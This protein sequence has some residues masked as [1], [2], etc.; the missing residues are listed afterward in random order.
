VIVAIGVAAAAPN[1]KFAL[2]N[3]CGNAL[4]LA[5]LT[6]CCI[7]GGIVG[8]RTLLNTELRKTFT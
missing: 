2:A 7:F 8:L 3:A 1:S 5:I 4:F 6:S